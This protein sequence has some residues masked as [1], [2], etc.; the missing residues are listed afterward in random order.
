MKLLRTL[1]LYVSGELL[2]RPTTTSVDLLQLL[3]LTT[4]A[5]YL[6]SNRNQILASLVSTYSNPPND[7]SIAADQQ[8]FRSIP[9]QCSNFHRLF[10]ELDESFVIVDNII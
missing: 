7:N 2:F 8:Q 4:K 10:C 3:K 9:T 1:P 6:R 5:Q